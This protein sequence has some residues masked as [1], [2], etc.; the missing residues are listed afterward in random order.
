MTA[1]LIQEK[2]NEL[3]DFDEPDYDKLVQ[4]CYSRCFEKLLGHVDVS[5]ISW[6]NGQSLFDGEYNLALPVC[7]IKEM[8]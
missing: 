5:I 8:T 2:L 6:D 4:L 1:S 7:F 3:P